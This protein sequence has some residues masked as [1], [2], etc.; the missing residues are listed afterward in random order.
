MGSAS[1]AILV[2]VWLE[3]NKEGSR[4]FKKKEIGRMN[5]VDANEGHDKA[6]MFL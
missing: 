2:L 6:Y 4:V 5:N 3:K 1:R